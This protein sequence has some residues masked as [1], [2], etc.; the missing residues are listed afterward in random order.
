MPPESYRQLTELLANHKT[1]KLLHHAQAI[2]D[3]TIKALHSL[4]QLL[5]N[6]CMLRALDLCDEPHA[7]SA[8]LRFLVSRGAVLSFE[9][10][11]RELAS[12]SQPEQICAK[13]SDLAETL[14][15]PDAAPPPQIGGA[16]RLDQ[17]TAIR[18]LAKSWQNCLA[19][20]LKDI[21]AGSYAVYLWDH[22]NLQA[23]CLVRRYGRL[24]WFLKEVRGPRNAA[25]EPK[26]LAIIYTAF[27]EAGISSHEIIAAILCMILESEREDRH[28][29][30]TLMPWGAI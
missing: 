2:D 25:I 19:Q 30:G 7:F 29:H 27:S 9:E 11:V 12:I 26:Q 22:P 14:P 20:Y 18:S 21:N 23:A 3:H 17:T 16:R 10:F 15:L 1:A 4:P 13:I 6:P 8:G 28:G 24:G 5:R